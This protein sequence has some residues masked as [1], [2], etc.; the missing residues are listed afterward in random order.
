[1]TWLRLRDDHDPASVAVDALARSYASVNASV[2]PALLKSISSVSGAVEVEVAV[3]DPS[4][5][6]ITTARFVS[7]GDERPGR[8]RLSGCA[9]PFVAS[10]VGVES[11]PRNDAPPISQSVEPLAVHVMVVPDASPTARR[12]STGSP[13][14]CR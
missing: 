9:A 2:C 12:R 14:G 3:P 8:P 1:V 6:A 10:S 4:S 7:P 5:N 11:I 13:S